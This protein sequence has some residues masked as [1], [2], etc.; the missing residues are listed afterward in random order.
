MSHHIY[1]K[2]V[3]FTI[4]NI[5]IYSTYLIL[6]RI[7]SQMRKTAEAAGTKQPSCARIWSRT[8]WKVLCRISHKVKFNY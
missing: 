8:T 3:Y 2:R 6:E 5:L 1:K 7:E 4:I